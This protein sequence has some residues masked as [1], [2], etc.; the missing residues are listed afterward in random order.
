MRYPLLIMALSAPGT[1]TFDKDE[2]G[3]APAGFEFATTAKTP[4]GKW[5]VVKDGE[6]QVLAQQDAGGA[7]ARFAM[8]VV[9]DSS[10]KDLRLSVKGKPVAG[11]VDQAVGLVWRYQDPD[12]YYVARSNALEGNV[13]LYKVVNA[14]RIMFG[15]KED[16]KIETGAWQS[17]QV[18]QRGKSIKVSLNDEALFEAADETFAAAGKVGV[19]IKADSVTHFDDLTAEELK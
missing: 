11:K 1:W 15:T 12:N 13:R 16:L 2:V 4:A 18:E 7:D 19:W 14:K 6:R 9:K 5:V 10:F 17:L 8:A 3:R